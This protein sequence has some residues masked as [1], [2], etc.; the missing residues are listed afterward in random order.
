LLG[1]SRNISPYL[2]EFQPQQ[3]VAQRRAAS[4]HYHVDGEAGPSFSD[5]TYAALRAA[6]TLLARSDGPQVGTFLQ[7]LFYTLDA[8]ANWGDVQLC[9]WLA[10]NITDWTQYQHRYAVPIQL[11]SKLVNTKNTDPSSE[12]HKS[13]IAMVT[14]VF[15]AHTPIANLST[16][17]ALTSLIGV[18]LRRIALNPHDPLL[19]DLVKCVSSLGTHLYYADQIHDLAEE[20]IHRLISV[21]VTGLHLV[22]CYCLYIERAI[23]RF[24]SMDG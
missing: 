10:L 9:C 20:L 6:K 19:L 18:I 1:E 12:V 3:P 17:D 2:S 5:V 4:I 15:S 14:A 7:A 24:R 11:I 21:Q 23:P 8:E 16:S 13:L 22:G